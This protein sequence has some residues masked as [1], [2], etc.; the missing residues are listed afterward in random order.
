[1]DRWGVI[2]LE[3]ISQI[4]QP[5]DVSHMVLEGVS[6]VVIRGAVGCDGLKLTFGRGGVADNGAR[7][8]TGSICWGDDITGL[9]DVWGSIEV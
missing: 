5:G 3:V 8:E 4:L 2:R 9:V 6:L 1:V 7:C